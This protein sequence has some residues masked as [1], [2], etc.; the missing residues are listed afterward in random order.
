MW[1]NRFWQAEFWT[2][3]FI[4]FVVGLIGSLFDRA[5][6][7][8]A[9]IIFGYLLW[10]LIQLSRL[11]KWL[12]KSKSLYPPSA[13]GLWGD[14]FNH[15][16]VLQRKNRKELKKLKGII[17]EFRA[18]TSAL[19]EGALII[20]NQGEIRWF[21]KAS[22]KL[23]GLKASTDIGQ[24]LFNLLRHPSFIE[25]EQVRDYEKPLTIPSPADEKLM[26]N[27]H[28]TPYNND[29]RLVMI[30]DV[31]EKHHLERVR[32]D[33]VANVSHE[34]R[35]P[36]TVIHG[37]L[38]ML[39]P[40]V[41][42]ELSKVEKPLQMMRQQ[43]LNMGHLVDDLLLL[44]R[45]DA[46]DPAHNGNKKD[47]DINIM[48]DSICAEARVLSGEKNQTILFHSYSNKTFCGSEKQL[49]SAFSNLVFNAVRYTQKGGKIDIYWKET[50]EN[51]VMSV[52]DNGPGIEEEHI[53][54]LTE[55][56]YRVDTGRNRSQG[57]TG[58]GLAIVKHV[59]EMHGGYLNIQSTVGKGSEFSCYLPKS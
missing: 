14:I 47:I 33:F 40:E 39:D 34:L 50:D 29:Q 25:Y 2:L 55:R 4:I 26:L 45:L 35:T 54:R 1:T 28:I 27:I 16:Y 57:G 44:S 49:R 38:E 19:K 12:V 52:C 32:Q 42:P 24:R 37:Y 3:A 23:L 46:K 53:P 8:I 51:L 48:L 13:P 36:L 58:L 56:F 9:V 22:E 30:R 10:N 6:A 31:T 5:A 59:L 41:Y 7:S 17:S 15:L 21:N 20:S 43:A 11:Y 18:S